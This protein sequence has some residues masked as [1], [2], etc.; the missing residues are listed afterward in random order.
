MDNT[1]LFFGIGCLIGIV[2]FFVC[3][4]LGWLHKM[5]RLKAAPRPSAVEVERDLDEKAS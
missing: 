5:S 2:I 4:R 1:A 3:E